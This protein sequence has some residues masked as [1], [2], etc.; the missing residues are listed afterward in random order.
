MVASVSLWC[1]QIGGF[2]PYNVISGE[3]VLFLASFHNN[4]VTL[5]QFQVTPPI[6]CAS[7]HSFWGPRYNNN[8]SGECGLTKPSFMVGAV[9]N[10][11]Y[12]AVYVSS[13][14]LCCNSGIPLLISYASSP[15]CFV[16][17]MR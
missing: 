14:C 7:L 13:N 5:S 9:S 1:D 17:L 8:K 4:D 2:T 10:N 11:Q 6:P 15:D 16:G 3:H 12:H